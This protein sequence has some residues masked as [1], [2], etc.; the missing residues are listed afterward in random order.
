MAPPSSLPP[1]VNRRGTIVIDGTSTGGYDP[2]AFVEANDSASDDSD[3]EDY[4]NAIP[5][6]K[7]GPR[8]MSS[9]MS[10]RN[11]TN[12]DQEK[13]EKVSLAVNTVKHT[14][15]TVKHSVPIALSPTLVHLFT[16]CMCMT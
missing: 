2:T 14:V 9:T 15:N 11:M 12:E 1:R 5:E 3:E 8:R 16:H 7:A 13:G 4:T 6:A 10:A